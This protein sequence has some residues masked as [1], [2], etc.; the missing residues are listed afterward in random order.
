MNAELSILAMTAFSV[1]FLHTILGP[2]HYIPFVAMSRTNQWSAR[3]TASITT[4]CGLGHVFGSVL[5]GSIGLMCGA[6]L[7]KIEVLESMRGD[8]AAWLLIG[9]GLAY[10][11][12]GVVKA[13]RDVP[14]THM[15]SHLDGT[16]HAHLH[17]HDLEHRHLHQQVEVTG[18]PGK[19][20]GSIAP[21]MLFLIFAFGPCE[22]LIPLLMYPA[23]EANTFAIFVVVLAFSLATIG[24]M[25]ALVLLIG[26]GLSFVCLPNLH[27]YSHALGGFAVLLCGVLVKFGL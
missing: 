4:L 22:V 18:E 26:F 8:A 3:K 1:G 9:F 11:T 16:I 14:H 15:H 12:W 17:K 20:P 23:A 5:I 21:W 7:M 19:Q 2:D 24:T 6:M 27:R 10:L 25:L 13:V